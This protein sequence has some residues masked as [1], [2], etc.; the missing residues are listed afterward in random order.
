MY[1]LF[2]KILHCNN[3]KDRKDFKNLS[4]FVKDINHISTTMIVFASLQILCHYK[5]LT[6][7]KSLPQ[8]SNYDFKGKYHYVRAGTIEIM[9][10]K[11]ILTKNRFS[12][13]YASVLRYE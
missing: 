8:K 6:P 10:I 9:H 11:D 4:L 12:L 13:P 3:S 7:S 5:S 2:C 1:W